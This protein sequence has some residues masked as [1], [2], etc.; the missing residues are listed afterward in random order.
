M[1]QRERIARDLIAAYCG[2]TRAF[3]RAKHRLMEHFRGERAPLVLFVTPQVMGRRCWGKTYGLVGGGALI[4][5]L[6]PRLYGSPEN[7]SRTVVHEMAH[8]CAFSHNE[9]VAED[10]ESAFFHGLTRP[11]TG[12]TKRSRRAKRPRRPRR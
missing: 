1:T 9:R 4:M 11:T 5:L 12:R 6:A 3:T 8:A 10:A 2:D 7:F